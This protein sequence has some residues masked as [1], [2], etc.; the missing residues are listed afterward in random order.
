MLISMQTVSQR[1][2]GLQLANAKEAYKQIYGVGG[3]I[4]VD[5]GKKGTVDY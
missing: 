3:N 2:A 1:A 5:K 4:D